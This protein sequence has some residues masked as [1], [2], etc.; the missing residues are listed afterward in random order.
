MEP[1]A[2]LGPLKW[3]WLEPCVPGVT[4]S[5]REGSWTR[6]P[7]PEHTE[8]PPSQAIPTALGLLPAAWPRW[9]LQGHWVWR[10]PP[11]WSSSPGASQGSPG[12]HP[13]AWQP[14]VRGGSAVALETPVA[15]T[16][17]DGDAGEADG[18]RG[19]QPWMVRRDGGLDTQRPPWGRGQPPPLQPHGVQQNGNA[20]RPAGAG[21]M[22][23]G[24]PLAL[25]PPQDP[26]LLCPTC[27]GII[28]HMPDAHPP[29]CLQP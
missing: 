17:A 22:S 12:L 1:A 6:C 14:P 9:V 25:S 5:P 10:L 2:T 21:P 3:P 19:G 23:G 4:L 15:I 7:H 24:W 13:P 16:A 11:S 28:T 20:S 18:G 29:H 27:P 8:V 26:L